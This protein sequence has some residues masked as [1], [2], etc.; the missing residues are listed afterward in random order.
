MR[1]PD[2][3]GG[4]PGGVM[5]EKEQTME[6][7]TAG[8]IEILRRL[9]AAF[10]GPPSRDGTGG[11][12][13]ELGALSRDDFGVQGRGLLGVEYIRGEIDP[14]TREFRYWITEQGQAY[15]RSNPL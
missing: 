4:C 8:Q 7:L 6:P 1:E 11:N 15:L 3:S 12:A 14:A 9:D 2:D 10:P 5:I 13:K